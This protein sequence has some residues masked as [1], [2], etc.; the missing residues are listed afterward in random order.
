MDNL[1]GHHWHY[2]P[3][4]EVIDLLDGNREEGLDLFEV[5][6][7]REQFGYNVLTAKKGKGPLLR[8]LLQFHQPLVYILLAATVITLLLQEWVDAGVIFGVVL[9][10]S[11]SGS[12]Q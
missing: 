4:E 2:L 10:N 8:F 7:R 12:L 6:H 11:V 5:N 3:D 1:I 9:V